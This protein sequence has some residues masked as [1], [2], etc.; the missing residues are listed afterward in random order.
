MADLRVQ[1]GGVEFKNPVVASAGTPTAT[2]YTI[3]KCMEAGVGAICTKSLGIESHTWEWSRPFFYLFDKHGHP[4][5]LQVVGEILWEA[6]LGIEYIKEV[7]P[8]AERNNCKIIANFACEPFE[9]ESPRFAKLAREAEKA[10]AD[11]IEAACPCPGLMPSL[12]DRYKFYEETLGKMI[13]TFKDAVK[14]P[15]FPKMACSEATPENIKRIKEAGADG[16][17]FFIEVLGA[18]IDIETGKPPGGVNIPGLCYGRNLGNA[19]CYWSAEVK[20]ITD[21]PVMESG[22][23]GTARDAIERTM[24]GTTLLAVCTAAIHRGYKVF[25]EMIRGLEDFMERK[26]YK[27]IDEFRGISIPYINNLD[28]ISEFYAR[29]RL[30]KEDLTLILDPAKCSHCKKCEGCLFGAITF[31]DEVPEVDLGLCERCGRCEQ[32]CPADAIT[33]KKV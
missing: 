3:K 1:F 25:S 17:S 6:E 9:T 5:N 31:K 12:E 10:G 19:G 21:L 15:V 26:G 33:I 4:G 14:I 16:I 8:E 13:S 11:L 30:K 24:C 20:K 23:I 32:I 27:S 29:K 18:S 22:G 7:K 2:P 28:K